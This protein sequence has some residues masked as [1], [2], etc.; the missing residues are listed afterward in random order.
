ML[1]GWN[2]QRQRGVKE[3]LYRCLEELGATK[4]ALYLIGDSGTFELASQYGFGRRD[5]VA[6]EIGAQH[7]LW[8][9]I[10]RHRTAPAFIN[11][12]SDDPAM[13]KVLEGAGTARLLTFPINAGGELVGFVE[14]RDKAKR[15]PFD[16]DDARVARSIAGGIE[17]FLA[18]HGL[19][20]ATSATA[21][22]IATV[23]PA[24]PPSSP[25][26]PHRGA[27]DEVVAIVRGA[28]S[29]RD[30]AIAA[31]TVTDKTS[32]RLHAFAGVPLESAQRDALAAHQASELERGGVRL[33]PPARWAWTEDRSSGPTKSGDSIHTVVLHAGPPVWLVASLITPPASAAP[34]VIFAAASRVLAL[35][36]GVQ[37]YRRAA[38]N[39]ARVLLEPGEQSLPHLRQHSQAVSELAQR[40]AAAL[41]LGEDEEEFVTVVGYLHDV[42]MRELDYARAYRME[43]PSDAERRLYQRHPVVG[44]RIVESAEFP[45]DLAS[46]IRSHHERWDGKGYP[47]RSAGD[48]IPLA[49]RIVHIAE[50]YDVLTS[51]SSYRR[52]IGREAALE[53]IRGEAGKQFDPSLVPVLEDIV[54]S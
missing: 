5:A 33:P 38:R 47:A 6:G 43:R 1:E 17:A 24:P 28:A 32:V 54:R 37:R 26:F 19:C 41:R 10:R 35:A 34:G 53:L 15:L 27:F 44:A 31:V 18:E 8:D 4:A 14:A 30:V 12:A 40:M 39:L 42:G 45:G 29:L 7:P 52:T 16:K 9:W 36:L 25:I 3:F 11:D 51:P 2:E 46:A 50:V 13:F 48:V 49:S 20:G 23:A 22:V 21:P